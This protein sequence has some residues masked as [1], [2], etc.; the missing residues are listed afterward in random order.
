MEALSD[1]VR[2]YLFRPHKVISPHEPISP[3]P[4]TP[5]MATLTGLPP[6]LLLSIFNFLPLV[7]LICFSLCNHRLLKLSRRQM[8][9]LPRTQDD[10]LSV[11]NRLERDFPEYFACDFC[12]VLHRFDGSESFGLHE[13]SY[14]R[15][16]PVP[17]LHKAT[18]FSD[19]FSLRTHFD[20]THSP[21]R[22][23]FIQIKLAMK[24]FHYGPRSGVS[25][26]SLG[27]TQVRHFPEWSVRPVTISLFSMEAQICPKP[28][29]LY[30]RMQDI[31]L[32]KTADDL[33]PN[34]RRGCSDPSWTFEICAHGHF[35]VF[36]P[37]SWMTLKK[38]GKSRLH[39]GVYV[40][41]AA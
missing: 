37:L 5:Y 41:C 3:C 35:L 22:L 26:D 11:L 21:Y 25:T 1:L 38:H 30:I 36:S 31:L 34:P 29:G 13:F 39:M 40:R 14:Q 24:R 19:D 28:F 32:V 23:L 16:C 10:K 15:T 4:K 8:N 6:E 12:K 2:S 20:W 9:R 18:W 7:D 33:I 17:C 27:Y